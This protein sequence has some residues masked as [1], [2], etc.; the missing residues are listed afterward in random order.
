[1]RPRAPVLA[2]A[3]PL[4]AALA[5]A[6]AACTLISGIDDLDV[7][8]GA[9]AADGGDGDGSSTTPVD[10]PSEP[11]GDDDGGS[12][13]PDQTPPTTTTNECGATGEWTACNAD[14]SDIRSCADRCHALGRTCVESCCA[15]DTNGVEY[16]GTSG[17]AYA[18][19]SECPQT[20]MPT[21][22]LLGTCNDL[23]LSV[24]ETLPIRCCC[25]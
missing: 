24:S 11:P 12:T 18:Y 13:L 15:Y 8:R 5:S 19:T 17:L 3:L 22:A 21:E 25:R 6:T 1:M 4:C 23:T 9:V 14:A 16:A 20:S 2:L 10:P 7:R